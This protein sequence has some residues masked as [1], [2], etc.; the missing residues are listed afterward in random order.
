VLENALKKQ[1]RATVTTISDGNRRYGTARKRS[2]QKKPP[3][4]HNNKN[5][6]KAA[7]LKSN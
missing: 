4:N 5:V 3:E 2:E 6:K 7:K 1:C